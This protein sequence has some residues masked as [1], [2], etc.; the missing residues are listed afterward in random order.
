ML[1]DHAQERLIQSVVY[2]AHTTRK[3]GK[4]KL[5]KLL[6]FLDFQH[7]RDTGHPVTDL[8]YYAWKMGPVPKTLHEQIGDGRAHEIFRTKVA[9][10]QKRIGDREMLTVN[11]LSAFDATH[12]TRR[13]LRMLD[14][15]S[16]KYR[17]S[18]AAEM[19]EQ[20]HLENLPWHQIW[21]VEKRKQAEIPYML[22]ARRQEVAEI[23][24]AVEDRM[25][26]V[27]AFSK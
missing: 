16:A 17:D 13:Q 26:I 15:L 14:E 6:Y 3:L 10:E 20:T 12:F 4:T 5:Y 23:R 2:F 22:A 11:A 19:I 18:D 27:R 1:V 25:E 9:F 8:T 7:F 21:E 24:A